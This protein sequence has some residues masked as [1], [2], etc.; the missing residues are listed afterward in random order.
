MKVVSSRN[1]FRYCREHCSV[2]CFNHFNMFIR[3]PKYDVNNE[4]E[5]ED[6]DDVGDLAQVL[7][8]LKNL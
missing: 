6:E 7:F 5:E 3:D 2:R 1:T 8:E 4:S